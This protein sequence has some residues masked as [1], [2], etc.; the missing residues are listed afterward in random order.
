MTWGKV[1]AKYFSKSFTNTSLINP[2]NNSVTDA[3]R[4][5]IFLLLK[6]F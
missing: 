2:Y 3:N 4:I 6:K 1:C 5:L